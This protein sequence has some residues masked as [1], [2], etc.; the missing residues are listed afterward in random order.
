V[1]GFH[2]GR[3][4]RAAGPDRTRVTKWEAR[5]S[6]WNFAKHKFREER[7]SEQREEGEAQSAQ[8]VF[9]G[10]SL[11]MTFG[12][13]LYEPTPSVGL[14]LTGS[15]TLPREGVFCKKTRS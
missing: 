3:R 4:A 11:R 1:D 12:S 10:G 8:P 15:A 2:G 14:A 9:G 6:E 5:D 7:W 13:Q